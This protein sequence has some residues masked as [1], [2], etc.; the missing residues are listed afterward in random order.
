MTTDGATQP[1]HGLPM[2]RR[3][4]PVA[5]LPREVYL[6]VTNRCNLRC[7]TCPRTHVEV[8]P[9]A[10]LGVERM[11][12]LT[13]ELPAIDRAVLH[14]VGEPLLHPDVAVMVG[15]LAGRGAHVVLNTNGTLLDDRRGDDVTAAGLGELRVSLDAATPETFLRV[16]GAD[17]LPRILR[18]VERFTTRRATRGE[19]RPE[20]SAWATALREN[21]DELPDL[22]RT[23]AAIGVRR[24]HLQRLVF[25]GLGLAVREQS[26]YRDLAAREEAVLAACRE[27]AA[28]SG[29][30]LTGSGGTHGEGAV[31]GGRGAEGRPW[32]SCRRPWKVLYVT[33]H[34]NV[35][36][37]CIAPFATT[38]FAAITLGNVARDG[39]AGVW[40]GPAMRAFRRRHQGDD[41]PAPC[42]PCGSEWSL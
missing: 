42:R 16:R 12:R 9:P 33:A 40:N 29:V 25:N 35:M 27:A 21:L 19:P 15:H 5:P 37:C 38:D 41:P 18:N 11:L 17:V 23:A 32:Q 8:E 1:A 34:G 20:V 31:G 10:D 13:D 4:G 24:V 36:P 14:G 28:A 2:P 30:A 22:V 26:V 39:V 6:E 3:R 7:G